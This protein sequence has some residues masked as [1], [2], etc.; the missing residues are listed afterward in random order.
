MRGGRLLLGSVGVALAT[1]VS[2]C[3]AGDQT[4]HD[5]KLCDDALSSF[6]AV[7]TVPETPD[8]ARARIELVRAEQ[9]RSFAERCAKIPGWREKFDA[10]Y[11]EAKM[12]T[13]I[14]SIDVIE[15]APSGQ[16]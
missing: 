2:A 6:A 5:A 16:P 7:P 3:G 15:A 8:E 13:S 11:E 1:L 10:A 4:A 12:A 9:E 14:I